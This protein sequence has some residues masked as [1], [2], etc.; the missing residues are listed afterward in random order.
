MEDSGQELDGETV[1]QVRPPECPPLMLSHQTAGR[2]E[3]GARH[4]EVNLKSR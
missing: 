2:V 1:H 4:G 3:Y